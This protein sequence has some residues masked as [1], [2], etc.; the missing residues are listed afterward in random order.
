MQKQKVT[1]YDVA[2]ESQVSMATVS[3]VVNG[4]SNVRKETRDHVLKVIEDMNYH[5][6]AVAQGL[7]SKKTTTVGLIVPGFTNLHFAELA[8]GIHDIANMYNYNIILSSIEEDKEEEAKNVIQNLLNKQV[9]GVIYMANVL[10][11]NTYDTFKNANV[12]I[13]LAATVDGNTSL[14]SVSIDFYKADKEA[15]NQ[16]Y[17]DGK[18]NIALVLGNENAYVNKEKRIV[19]Y[20]EFL[21]DHN[22]NYYHVYN[23]IKTYQDGYN[24]F[25]KLK[26]DKIDGLLATRDLIIAGIINSTIDNQVKIPDD[27]EFISAT[28]TNISEVVR[29]KLTSFKQP[30]YD[31]GAITMRMLT[32]LMNEEEIK[33]RQ[34][35]LPYKL[36]LGDTTS[37]Q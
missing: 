31:V 16:L 24:L 3:R 36:Q 12:P 19:A 9:D 15:F 27:I 28:S 37:N 17:K 34:I 5:P 8:K 14:S 21:K 30:L 18:N 4:N 20:K 29:P 10:T 13:V 6:N 33:E 35:I 11:K 7:A 32:K 2:R 22:L 23:G 1:I 26:K 25:D